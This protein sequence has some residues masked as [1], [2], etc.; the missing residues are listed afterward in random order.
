MI[1]AVPQTVTV[2][3]RVYRVVFEKLDE[4][5]CG[6]CTP[7]DGIIR[8]NEDIETGRRGTFVHEVLH[9]IFAE[10]GL[11]KLVRGKVEE[12]IVTALENGLLRSGIIKE[13]LTQ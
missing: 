4:E 11:N 10:A 3:G 9:A 1:E 6:D 12:A 5:T 8:L 13:N 7:I 2:M